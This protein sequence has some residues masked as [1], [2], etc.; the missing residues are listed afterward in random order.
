MFEFEFNELWTKVYQLSTCC[1]LLLF[2]EN[3]IK[4]KLQ[5][6]AE[7]LKSDQMY[8][9]IQVNWYFC[10]FFTQPSCARGVVVYSS[11]PT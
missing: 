11:S 3:F 5:K 9:K 4:N 7:Q 10:Q 8:Q 6:V 1:L 2:L